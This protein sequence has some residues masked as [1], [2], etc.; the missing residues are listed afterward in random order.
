[1]EHFDLRTEI[2]IQ[3]LSDV[4]RGWFEKYSLEELVAM[5]K[6]VYRREV[7]AL[8]SVL[9]TSGLL[10]A[11]VPYYAIGTGVRGL[12]LGIGMLLAILVVIILSC[13]IFFLVIQPRYIPYFPFE[14][15]YVIELKKKIATSQSGK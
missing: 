8:V 4:E 13:S 3:I 5:R 1:M 14:F 7:V 2:E 15:D 11:V 10:A 9:L 12:A 6:K